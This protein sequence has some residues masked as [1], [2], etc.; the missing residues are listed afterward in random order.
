MPFYSKDLYSLLRAV[1]ELELRIKMTARLHFA[2]AL[3]FAAAGAAAFLTPEQTTSPSISLLT[4]SSA[5]I[6]SAKNPDR[7]RI[8]KELEDI[9]DHDWRA[10][11]ARLVMNEALESKEVPNGIDAADGD[12]IEDENLEKQHNVGKLFAGAISSIF[13]PRHQQQQQDKDKVFVSNHEEATSDVGSDS[14]IFDG[15]SVGGAT[16]ESSLP[17]SCEDPFISAAEL[18]VIMQPKGDLDKH[19]WAHPVSTCKARFTQVSSLSQRVAYNYSSINA[20]TGSHSSVMQKHL[21]SI[22]RCSSTS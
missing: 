9:M 18:P 7:A 13:S 10:F 12:I 1:V 22:H 19:R 3:L 8:E 21:S 20:A 14:S 15:D 11:R 5:T 6:L 17:T 16:S 4:S 2:L